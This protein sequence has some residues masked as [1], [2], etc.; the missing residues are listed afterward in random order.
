MKRTLLWCMLA[1]LATAFIATPAFAQAPTAVIKIEG[2]SIQEITNLGWTSPRSTGLSVVGTGQLVYLKGSAN[3]GT[4]TTYAWSLTP[5]AGSTATLD[6]TNKLQTTFKPDIVGKYTVQLTVTTSA[7]T[8]APA[9]VTIT[10]AKF[11][12]VGMMD[13]LPVDVAA[14]Q[15]ALCHNANFTAWTKTAHAS[16][17]KE[18]L[19]GQYGTHF[20][21][22]C[23][24]CHST[25]YDKTAP[26]INDGFD[27]VQKEVG[28]VFPATLQAGNYD[29]LK[30]NYPK[31]AA[32]ANTQ[33]ESCHGPGSL[34][35]G[36]KTSI[37]MNLEEQTCGYCHEE[38]PFNRISIQWKNSLH[39][40]G[41]ASASTNS[42]CTK[43]HS[44]WGFIRRV[45]PKSPD[46]RPTSGSAPTSCAVCH[47]PHRSEVLPN[48]VRSLDNVTLGDSVTVVNYGGMG[49]ICMQCHISRRDAEDYTSNVANLS[50]NFGP[51]HSNQADMLD[52][53]NAVEY[54]IPIGS[55]GHKVAVA[56]ACVT[57]HMSA[58]PA[59]GQ[60]GHDKIGEHTY[61]M[62]YDN[63]TP[64][65]PNDDVEN[66]KVCQT[67]HGPIKSFDD[68]QAKADFD[69][70]GTIEGTREEIEGMVAVL[71]KLLP[72]R[73]STTVIKQNYDWTL[74]GLT[75]AQVEK[76]KLYTK[77][78]YNWRFVAEDGSDGVHNAGYSLALLR[79][80]IGSL[81]TGDIG[82]GDII[83]ITDVPNDQG[84]QVRVAWS[85]APGDGI[86][87][88]PVTGY[89]LWRRVDATA[90]AN[91]VRVGSKEEL[92]AQG[93]ESN[94]GKR[95]VVA[96][97]AS[98]T[99]D[100]VA[101]V[102]ASGYETYSIVAPTLYDS[103]ATGNHWSVFYVSG[104]ARGANYESE[105]DSGYSVDN[106]APFAPGNVSANVV[107]RTVNLKWDEA[108]DADFQYY[109]IYRGTTSG[110][111]PNETNRIAQLTATEYADGGLD[112]GTTYYYRLSTFDFA[113]NQSSFTAELPVA[114]T[115]VNQS[116]AVPTVYALEQNYPNPFNPE[117]SIKYQLA[118][119]GHVR[120]SVYTSLGQE[121]RRLLDRNQSAAYYVQ[122]WD[123]RD[124]A[125]NILPSGVYFYRLESGS[126]VAIKKMIMMK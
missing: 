114:V 94:L 37:A 81:T 111:T 62:K 26:A 47:D 83:S 119:S 105:P 103:S 86:S 30:A 46:T 34:H 73:T 4:V 96:D 27:D 88:N 90:G 74:P 117:T 75:P 109:A 21:E 42:S 93:F 54:G 9:A 33:C 104:L 51:H 122:S 56:D 98:S 6:S 70:D 78:W 68:I 14:G 76:R 36:D 19:D 39:A 48:M 11:V 20:T 28:W 15:C 110:F 60:P 120:L 80:S 31:L 25:G 67:C 95:F 63:G 24:E 77:A 102:P 18:G 41:V 124:D 91:V 3:T 59:A 72:P 123:G 108:I 23:L 16:S 55:S 7:G 45:D 69:E 99:W 40:V 43:C 89:A 84:K 115:S 85:K 22:D 113:G 106:L 121:V 5:P 17:L 50:T 32:R 101:W 92:I 97:A 116:V 8:S 65:D 13:G 82:A 57:C 126:F 100:F 12:G 71:D 118:K 79:R 58:T 1:L 29:A 38:E 49:K 66:I 35:K 44:G 52:G 10:A 64:T 107:S 61:S 112:V 87:T 125:G 2:Y 53:S